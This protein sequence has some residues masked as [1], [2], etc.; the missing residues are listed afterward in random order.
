[1][2]TGAYESALVWERKGQVRTC[3][4]KGHTTSWLMGGFP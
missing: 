2:G 1:M 3:V 4:N